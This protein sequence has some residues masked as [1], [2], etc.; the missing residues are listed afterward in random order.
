MYVDPGS[1]SILFQLVGAALLSGLF[2][3][4]KAVGAFF[5]RLFRIR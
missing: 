1:G 4:R 3:F 5:Q 2:A